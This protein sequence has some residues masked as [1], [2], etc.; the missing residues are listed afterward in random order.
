LYYKVRR[1][2]KTMREQRFVSYFRVSTDKQG[3]SGLGLDAQREAVSQFLSGRGAAV[4]AEFVEI[5]SGSK[6]DRPQLALALETCRRHKATLLIAKLDRLARN[7]AFIANLMDSA[8]DFVAVDMPHASRLVLHV[9]AAFGEHER[10]MISQRTKAA[11]AAAKARGV[12]LG[13]NG[14]RIAAQNHAEAVAY[15]ATIE[16][17]VNSARASGAKTLTA[18]AAYLN[19]HCVPSREDKHGIRQTWREPSGG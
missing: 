7:V 15:A 12:K 16:E 13:L 6:N 9:M 17:H 2:K 19:D 18:I 3:R 1:A 14:A 5:E 11:L 4:I 8:T 10:E